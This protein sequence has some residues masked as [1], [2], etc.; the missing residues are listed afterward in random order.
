MEIP[1]FLSEKIPFRLDPLESKVFYFIYRFSKGSKTIFKRITS[2]ESIWISLNVK[3]RCFIIIA[4]AFFVNPCH[5]DKLRCYWIQI[6]DVNSH[7]DWQT[8]QIHISWL[9][10]KPTDLDL[11]CL[12]KQGISG[13]QDLIYFVFVLSFHNKYIHWTIFVITSLFYGKTLNYMS[14]NVRLRTFTHM[15]PIKTQISLRIRAA[16]RSVH[17]FSAWR[18]FPTLAIQNAP[19][20][21]SDQ[22]ARMH[23]A[24]WNFAGSTRQKVRFLK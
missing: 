7:T 1:V 24:I 20:G 4:D 15:C 8:V 19:S 21:D 22:T 3:L 23:R 13:W 17:L 10:Q 2:P 16:I 5:A 11:H 14:S 9:L 12:Q 6:V 18:N